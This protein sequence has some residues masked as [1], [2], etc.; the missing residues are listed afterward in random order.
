MMPKGEP[1]LDAVEC[2]SC[3]EVLPISEA[4]YHQVAEKAEGDLKGK[5]LQHERALAAREQQLRT[6]SPPSNGNPK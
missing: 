4:I 3:G 5:T 1:V 6:L 2:P